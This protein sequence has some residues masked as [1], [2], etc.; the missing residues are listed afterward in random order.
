MALKKMNR[1]RELINLCLLLSGAGN[2]RVKKKRAL[3]SAAPRG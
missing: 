2:I 1:R 3:L